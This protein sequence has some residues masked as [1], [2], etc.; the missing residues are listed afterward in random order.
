MLEMI[1]KNL[2]IYIQQSFFFVIGIKI[3]INVLNMVKTCCEIMCLKRS[4]FNIK[5]KLYTIIK[6]FKKLFW[7][8]FLQESNLHRKMRHRFKGKYFF[9]N[10]ILLFF[11]FTKKNYCRFMVNVNVTIISAVSSV[12]RRLKFKRLIIWGKIKDQ[13]NILFLLHCNS[14][15]GP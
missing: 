11:F 13:S 10:Y 15:A 6:I 1:K 3:Y 2:L 9:F 12:K 14:L 7:C 4:H 5:N 8:F